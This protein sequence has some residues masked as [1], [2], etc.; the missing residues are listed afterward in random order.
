MTVS[1]G[2]ILL[3][4][5]L[6]KVQDM[7]LEALERYRDAGLAKEAQLAHK[8]ILMLDQIGFRMEEGILEDC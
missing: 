8:V 1:K 4:G 7:V 6:H 2:A 3:A 5:A